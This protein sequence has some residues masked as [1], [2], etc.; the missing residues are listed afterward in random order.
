MEEVCVQIRRMSLYKY[1]R[2]VCIQV[3][4]GVYISME[5]ECLQV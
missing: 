1:G 3:G 5:E 2:G 4:K